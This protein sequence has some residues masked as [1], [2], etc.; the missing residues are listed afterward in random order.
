MKQ[1]KQLTLLALIAA[2]FVAPAFCQDEVLPAITVF[3]R[4]YKY[5]KALDN[6]NAAQP[7]RLL[8]RQAA[9]YDVKNSEYYSDEYDSYSIN[10]FLPNGYIL[11]V[12]D[13]SGRLLRTAERFKN[14]ALPQ[15]VRDAVAKRYPNW[16]TSNDVY[17]VSYQEDKV[18]KK[19]YKLILENGNKRLRVKI[20]DAGEFLD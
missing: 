15:A 4:S 1:I 13:S 10:F 8:E 19:I 18:A 14:V 11:A 9:V 12:Y 7:V 5:L 6:K 17:K 3:A 16:S 2:G 20:N